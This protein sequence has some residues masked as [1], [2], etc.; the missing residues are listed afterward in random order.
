MTFARQ[1]SAEWPFVSG[2]KTGSRGGHV[3]VISGNDN[4]VVSHE[5][6]AEKDTRS[7]GQYHEVC[8]MLLA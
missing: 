2:V 3:R 7:A 6:A 1:Q 8:S 5:V 4:S